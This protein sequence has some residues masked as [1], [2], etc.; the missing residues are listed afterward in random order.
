MLFGFGA[1][2]ITVGGMA[3]F[4]PQVT[5]VVTMLLL[6]SLPAEIFVVAK[7]WREVA[8]RGTVL[9][10]IGLF[11]GVLIGTR[12]LAVSEPTFILTLLAVFLVA[13]GSAF[14]LVP[15]RARVRWP[16][17]T[18]PPIGLVSGVLT[19]LFGTGGPPLI[20][21]YQLA[22]VGKAEF[23]G[24]MMAIFMLATFVRIP[25][26][27]FSGLLTTPRIVSAAM[28]LPIALLGAWIG[29]RIHLQLSESR[30]RIL[31]GAALG[32]MGALLLLR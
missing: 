30:F 31:V 8:W 22:G 32:L 14:A 11:A 3:L 10:L 9:I 24:S 25:A 16:V 29:N 4:M 2:L 27:A 21:Y 18:G 5:D 12:I 15:P 13:A 1:G 26:Y 6:V 23:R 28:L 19:G 7:A 17:W 20:F